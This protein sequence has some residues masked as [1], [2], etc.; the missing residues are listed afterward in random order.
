MQE[1]PRAEE[2]TV[3]RPGI[4][5][6]VA[7]ALPL[8]ACRVARE[9]SPAGIAQARPIPLSVQRTWRVEQQ[10]VLLGYVVEL[11]SAREGD[12][13]V[14]RC[15]SVRNELQQELGLIDGL[16]RAWRFELHQREPRWVATGTVLEG[17]RAILG[18]ETEAT[19]VEASARRR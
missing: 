8:V 2:A 9:E 3:M 17:A 12:R 10:G 1:A 6:S 4:V 14:G 11:E 13:P 16:G 19:L 5:T 18:V 15:F 7:L